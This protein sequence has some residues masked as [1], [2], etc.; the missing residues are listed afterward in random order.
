MPTFFYSFTMCTLVFKRMSSFNFSSRL[1]NTC[2]R[3][4]LARGTKHRRKKQ[5]LNYTLGV[6]DDAVKISIAE[7]RSRQPYKLSQT[8]TCPRLDTNVTFCIIYDRICLRIVY[9]L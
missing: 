5:H 8:G 6:G 9:I 7:I 4:H 2:N 3:F 1:T